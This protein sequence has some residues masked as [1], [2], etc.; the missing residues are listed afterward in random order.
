MKE[1]YMNSMAS[2]LKE[3]LEL[4]KLPWD[5]TYYWFSMPDKSIYTTQCTF[6]FGRKLKFVDYEKDLD[7]F[8]LIDKLMKELALELESETGKAPQVILLIVDS[9]GK[10]EFKFDYE[11]P[12]VMNISKIGLG[13]S[14]SYFQNDEMD[15][16]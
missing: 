8:D 16:E 12:E 9:Y 3:L 11:N 13:S 14:V 15:I 4:T 2:C 6:S 5:K 1:Q 10:F 7:Y